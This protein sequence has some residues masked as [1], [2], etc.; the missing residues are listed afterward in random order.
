MLVTRNDVEMDVKD[1]LER[2]LAI[3][4]K[5]VDP[6]APEDTTV[7]EGLRK[8]LCHPEHLGPRL[9]IQVGQKSS[10]TIGDD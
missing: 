10:V 8:S 4:Q 7:A 6:F 2:G 3:G 9:L 1:F 5:E